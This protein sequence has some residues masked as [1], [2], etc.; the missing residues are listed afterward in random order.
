MHYLRVWKTGKAGKAKS[1]YKSRRRHGL[2]GH[3]L[4]STW[5]GIM[6][7][8]YNK[9][10]ESYKNYGGRGIEV[11]RRWWDFATFVYDVGKKPTPLHTVNRIDNNGDYE[12][13]NFEWATRKEQAQNRRERTYAKN[14]T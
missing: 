2:D 11:C 13:L 8:C 5:E 7:R 14:N 1:T 6:Q 4:Q 9:N 10:H 12:P 3:P